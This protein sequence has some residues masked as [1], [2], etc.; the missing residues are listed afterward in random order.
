MVWSLIEL[1]SAMICASAPA[2]KGIVTAGL[3]RLLVK[4]GRKKKE[5]YSNDE[6]V[7]YGKDDLEK[8]SDI[9]VSVK[10]V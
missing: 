3:N 10:T 7:Q 2:V 5:S 9:S 4:L 1:H 6:F 8:T